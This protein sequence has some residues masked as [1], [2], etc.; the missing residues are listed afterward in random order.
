M[1]HPLDLR[2]TTPTECITTRIHP[3]PFLNARAKNVHYSDDSDWSSF[4][5]SGEEEPSK[6][7]K[8]SSSKKFTPAQVACLNRYWCNGLTSCKR[9]LAPQIGRAAQDC[10][11]TCDQVKV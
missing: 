10:G 5:D 6:L 1:L 9:E 11:L 7:L 8:S 4:I 3:P 2:L